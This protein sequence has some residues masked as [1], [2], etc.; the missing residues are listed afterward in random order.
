MHACILSIGDE[1]VLGQTVDTNSAHL[2]RRLAEYGISTLYHQTV[3]DDRPAI[4]KAIDRACRDAPLVIISGG[5]G[6]TDDDLTRFALADAIGMATDHPDRTVE[7]QLD[8]P[9]IDQMQSRYKSLGR[10][11]PKRNT[12]QAMKPLGA[13]MIENTC[14]TA[15][16]LR[17]TIHDALVF[18]TPG[19]P[20]EM[21]TMYDRDIEPVI[22]E[23]LLDHE[24]RV[25]RTS[26]INTF[27]TGE[28]NVAE[29]LGDLMARHRNP[30]VG[31]TVAKG[32]VSVRVRSESNDLEHAQQELEK[33]IAL[34]EAKLGSIVFSHNDVSL[35]AA[36]LD[37]LQAQQKTIATAESCTGG[38]L[39][40]MLTDVPG[41][42]A[43]YLGGWV[44]YT[45]DMKTA[46][47]AVNPEL[48]KTHGAVSEPVALAMA[49]AA[50][51]R[52][53]AHFALAIT[54]IAGPDGG[55][56]DK[57]VGTVY[58]ALAQHQQPTTAKRHQFI[59][60]RETI[61]DRAAKTALN[62]LRFQLLPPHN[63]PA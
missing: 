56:E 23:L 1:L 46:E 29:M 38:L 57:P 45:N 11:M 17:A 14:G 58:I 27:G 55:T 40:K 35:Q 25:I 6:P 43:A 51:T 22:R 5:L 31:T 21:F 4:A 39:G 30:T 52:T 61:R 44:T 7:L 62:T 2:S 50:R 47:L 63:S 33:T 59:G 20:R 13:T 9:S 15:P 8:Q 26:K 48:I 19:V 60:D 34:V 42:S 54:G 10:P 24:P 41:S 32:Y 12:V 18:I 36:T 16:G 53:N 3:A 37:I 49:D 28:S